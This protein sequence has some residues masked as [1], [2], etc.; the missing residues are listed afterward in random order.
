[1]RCGCADARDGK[2]EA[3]ADVNADG[4]NNSVHH[5]SRNGLDVEHG[6]ELLEHEILVLKDPRFEPVARTKA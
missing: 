1:M 5:P 2:P 4:I 6:C 3:H